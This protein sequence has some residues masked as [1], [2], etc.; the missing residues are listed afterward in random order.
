VADR[1]TKPEKPR[2]EEMLERIGKRQVEIEKKLDRV[3]ALL[4]A[5]P[6]APA[7][8]PSPA[9]GGGD[10][11][12]PEGTIAS[13]EDLASEHGNPEIRRDPPRWTG[14]SHVG[15]TFAEASAEFLDCLAGFLDWKARE[16]DKKDERT[17][18]GAPKS[19]FIRLDAARAR[20]HAAKKRATGKH[21]TRPVS[22]W[23][24]ETG[25]AP[26][27]AAPDDEAPPI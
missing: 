21:R 1:D 19:K 22:E 6:A 27:A 23:R 5:Q 3:L 8:A 12:P 11:G 13:D 24:K 16:S 25:G 17:K 10:L 26:R 7:H 9:A 15:K 20:G 18:G 14:E 4:E 2:T